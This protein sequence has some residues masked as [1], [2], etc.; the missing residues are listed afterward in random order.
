M[1][2]CEYGLYQHSGNG[3]ALN[4]VLRDKEGLQSLDTQTK[5]GHLA[6]SLKS[7]I[8]AEGLFY[9]GLCFG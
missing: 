9:T 1:D 6:F 5:K 2:F 3:F 4:S 8:L 7:R